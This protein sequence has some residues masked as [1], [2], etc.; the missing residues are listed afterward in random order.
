M[1]RNV[2][3]CQ[4]MIDEFRATQTPLFVAY[5]RRALPRFLAVRRA[6][7]NSE[8]GKIVSVS[9]VLQRAIAPAERDRRTLPWRVR[10]EIAG[11]GHFVY[12]ASHPPDFLDSPL[13]PNAQHGA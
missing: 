8:I 2:A 5:Y 6:I 3:E 11:G 4:S 10:P 9:I 1:A 13:G 7:E 12:L